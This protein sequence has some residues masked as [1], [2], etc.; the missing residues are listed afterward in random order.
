MAEVPMDVQVSMVNDPANINKN[1]NEY[2]PSPSQNSYTDDSI[3]YG[4]LIVLG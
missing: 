4:Q 3:V 2:T 1:K